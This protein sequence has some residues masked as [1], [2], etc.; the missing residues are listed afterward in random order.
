M[1]GHLH[2]DK[3][4]R[5]LPLDFENS[6]I[7][8]SY[9]CSHPYTVEYLFPKIFAFIFFGYRPNPTRVDSCVCA[10]TCAHG[11]GKVKLN[12]LLHKK[13]NHENNKNKRIF[14]Q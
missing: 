6:F 3:G 5:G 11:E 13:Y 12:F 9:C 1:I 7:T 4:K 8:V 14:S 10:W 2:K